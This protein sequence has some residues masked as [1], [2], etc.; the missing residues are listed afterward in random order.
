MIYEIYFH[1]FSSILAK[2]LTDEER[3][4]IR[5]IKQIEVIDEYAGYSPRQQQM[6]EDVEEYVK[7]LGKYVEYR[8]A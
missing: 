3:K 5:E 2:D 6:H 4:K 1:A 7:K 8:S